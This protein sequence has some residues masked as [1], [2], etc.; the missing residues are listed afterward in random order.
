MPAEKRRR[1]GRTA[2][3]TIRLNG[4]TAMA[5]DTKLLFHNK[6]FM[7]FSHEGGAVQPKGNGIND[8][9]VRWL[10]VYA[11]VFWLAALGI[12]RKPAEVS[13]T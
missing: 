12:V 2:N 13:C 6:K 9:F 4:W 3:G 11:V 7:C 1:N 8:G 5:D 10:C